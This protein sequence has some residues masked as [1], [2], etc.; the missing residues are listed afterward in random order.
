MN[1]GRSARDEAIYQA[2]LYPGTNVL[3]NRLDIRDTDRLEAAERYLVDR[4]FREGLPPEARELSYAGFKAI[5]RHL[6]QDVY[7]WAGQ[8]RR[9]TT[10]RGDAP[11]AVPEY[12]APWM[13]Q[14]FDLLKS[15]NNLV[16][17]KRGAFAAR[18]AE[19][20]NEIN[21]AHPFI[22]GNGRTQRTWLR[23][24]ADGARFQLT[25]SG[26][27]REA[28]NAASKMGFERSDHTPMA[29]LLRDRLEER[30]RERGRGRDDSDRER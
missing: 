25:L 11:F 26:Q 16:G 12:I 7:E 21:A 10:G 28:W 27:D 24:L 22:E 23:V 13:E 17:L 8:E 20:V 30:S 18:A 5:H 2:T 9:Y 1:Y 14:R 3:R 15:E 19:H 4:R 29:E 6:F